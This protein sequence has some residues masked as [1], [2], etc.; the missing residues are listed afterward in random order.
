MEDEIK[1]NIKNA[2]LVDEI[3]E[4]MAQ[5][6]AEVLTERA[7]PDARDGLKP[8]HRHFMFAMYKAN[9]FYK[10]ETVKSSN[11]VGD[12]LGKYHP[13]GDIPTYLSIVRAAQDFSLRY[14]LV[15]RQGNFGS[16]DGDSPAAHRYTEIKMTKIAE[17]LVRDLDKMVVPVK[18]NYDDRLYIPIVMPCFFPN[19][20]TNG[21]FGIG[22]G[23]ATSIPP[24]NL[25]EMI[26]ATI[27]ATKDPEISIK[28]LLEDHISGPDFPT[29]AMIIYSKQL[30]KAYETGRGSVV[31]RGKT[32]VEKVSSNCFLLVITEIPYLL[33]KLNLVVEIAKLVETKIIANV[34]DI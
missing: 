4:L 32:H 22:F 24:H 7:L 30:E 3:E 25:G 13:H 16:I 20:L 29:G 15:F 1:E 18:K 12:T 28:T 34:V 26:S 9:L 2:E 11:V 27:A 14:P 6:G 33:K 5:Y 17:E 10:N 31:I 23:M 8:V 19:L 21:S